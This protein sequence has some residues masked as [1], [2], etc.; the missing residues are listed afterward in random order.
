MNNGLQFISLTWTDRIPDNEAIMIVRDLHL[1]LRQAA[2]YLPESGPF[3]ALP[4]IKPFGYWV[5]TGMNP[6]DPYCSTQWYID[7]SFG[8]DRK[9]LH[10]WRYLNTVMNEP[11]Q[12][13]TPHYDLAV[14]HHPLIDDRQGEQV[15][16]LAIDG[17]AAVFSTHRLQELSRDYERPVVL[18]RLA[19]HFLGRVIGIPFPIQSEPSRCRGICVMRE[20]RHFEDWMAMADE[21]FRAEVI[22]CESCRRE[23]SARLAGNLMG[24]N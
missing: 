22:Y 14:L 23:L 12:F 20:A 5:L 10:G 17:R 11:Y 21:E 15:L 2:R 3:V 6:N 9:A 8:P 16:G 24:L 19:A 18:R 13:H 7:Q 4:E 1:A